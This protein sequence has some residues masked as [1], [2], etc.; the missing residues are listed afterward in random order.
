MLN[1][2]NVYRGPRWLAILYFAAIPLALVAQTAYWELRD[3]YLSHCFLLICW[4]RI[5]LA[6]IKRVSLAYPKKPKLN[7]WKIE[8]DLGAIS[9]QSSGDLDKHGPQ[10]WH[11]Q[12]ADRAGFLN[13]LR[14]LI[15]QAVIETQLT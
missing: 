5:P 8:Y 14:P 11:V 10:I 1:I 12:V 6:S 13:A 2:F 4:R 7:L 15:P 3:G 9:E